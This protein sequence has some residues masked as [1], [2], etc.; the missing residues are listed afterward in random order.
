MALRCVRGTPRRFHP[1]RPADR[2]IF[3]DAFHDRPARLTIAARNP[4]DTCREKSRMAPD[5][6]KLSGF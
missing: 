6:K 4:L 1:C 3:P 5:T 2:G